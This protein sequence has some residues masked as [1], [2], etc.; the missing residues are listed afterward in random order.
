MTIVGQD[1]QYNSEIQLFK[2]QSLFLN[3]ELF[4]LKLISVLF[5]TLILT[6]K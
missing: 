3:N 2:G 5:T 6:K 1:I 4:I